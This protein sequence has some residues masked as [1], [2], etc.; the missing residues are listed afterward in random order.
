MPITGFATRSGKNCRYRFCGK[1][2]RKLCRQQKFFSMSVKKNG[3]TLVRSIVKFST[4]NSV[5]KTF[6]IKRVA[7][8]ICSWPRMKVDN[9][10][11]LAR[12]IWMN[13]TTWLT[14][15]TRGLC[16]L[17]YNLCTESTVPWW[18]TEHTHTHWSLCHDNWQHSL[19][20]L[21]DCSL[22]SIHNSLYHDGWQSSHTHT[23]TH[24][25][26]GHCTMIIYRGQIHTGHCTMMVDSIHT[27]AMQSAL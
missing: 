2:W 18:L 5:I 24:T 11:V 19:R 6:G 20:G 17:L 26:T 9:S 23:H 14:A 4:T 16:R 8:L 7:D 13:S 27:G 10:T 22:T 1:K 21:A 3:A 12:L 15:F 25:H